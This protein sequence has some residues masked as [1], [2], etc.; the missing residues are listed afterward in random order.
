MVL[1][2]IEFAEMYEN[3]YVS[4][5][6]EMIGVFGVNKYVWRLFPI[7]VFCSVRFKKAFW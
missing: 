1:K 5:F 2:K 7:C 4:F 3:V 6:M